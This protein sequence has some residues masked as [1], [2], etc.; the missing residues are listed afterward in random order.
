MAALSAPES[1]SPSAPDAQVISAPPPPRIGEKLFLLL[2]V[3]VP[4]AGLAFAVYRLWNQAVGWH[5]LTL[6]LSFYVVTTVGIGAGFHRMLT[7]RGFLAPAPVRFVLLALGSLALE[8]PPTDWAATHLKHHAKSDHEGDPHSP[9]HGFWHA[10]V[11]WLFSMGQKV[12]PI[13]YRSL[14][15][16]RVAQAVSTT[17]PLWA[18]LSF[19]LPF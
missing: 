10:H 12:E 14:Q 15:N 13:Y 16:D 6:F 17:F 3:L 9:I 4:L 2:V 19:A 7:H 1:A 5:D 11:G 18:V 8:G